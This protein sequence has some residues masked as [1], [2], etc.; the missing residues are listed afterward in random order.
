MLMSGKL[1]V[2]M[3]NHLS[4]IRREYTMNKYIEY[5]LMTVTVVLGAILILTV[6]SLLT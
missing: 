3:T 1:V 6:I 4:V 5:I 2:D